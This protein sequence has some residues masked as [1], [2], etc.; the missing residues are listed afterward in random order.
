MVENSGRPEHDAL[1]A[2]NAS[3]RARAAELEEALAQAQKQAPPPSLA[4]GSITTDRALLHQAH[5]LRA[6]IENSPN[7]IFVKSGV[8]RRYVLVNR[9]MTQLF[10][11]SEKEM[12]GI[13]DTEFFPP[14]AA[15][16]MLAK[17]EEAINND[18]PIHFEEL[19]PFAD[20]IR[21]FLTVKFPIRGASGELLGVC[22]I[23]TD[24]TEQKQQ[25]AER[26]ALQEQVITAQREALREL[27]TPLM[28]IAEGVLVMPLV[29]SIDRT[30]ADQIMATLLEG[31]GRM[32]AHTAIVDI[33]GVRTVD[34]AVASALLSAARAVALLGARVVLTGIGPDVAQAL[35]QLGADLN[36]IVTRG[37]MQD[38]IAFALNGQGALERWR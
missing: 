24:I 9:R 10:N 21:H 27:S 13:H 18:A 34:T 1:V 15:K 5:L 6:V 11:K 35:V 20:G 3:L 29:G 31:I 38:G 23:A 16:E 32:R 30:R 4:P 14:E 25:Q 2:E 17:D 28:P 22:G 7:A 37:T 12:L 33:T 36:G 26:L 19:V 8:D